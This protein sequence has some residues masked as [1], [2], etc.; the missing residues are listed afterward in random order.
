[1]RVADV[2]DWSDWTTVNRAADAFH[3]R[4]VDDLDAGTT[5]EFQVRSVD[6]DDTYSAAVAALGTATG[7]Q[8]IS[9]A[10]PSGTV[11]EGEP[12]RFR[13][14]RDQ[15]HGRLMVILRISE[16]GDMLP[17]EGRQSNGLW[18]KSVYFGDG[19]RRYRWCWKPLTTAT[20]PSRTAE[21]PSR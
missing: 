21:S 19:T 16:T 13:L 4:F 2:S 11:T 1:M 18:T 7:P 9:I 6:K 20:R 5:Y 17:Q 15:P 10:R 14:S 12:L 3:S 8:T